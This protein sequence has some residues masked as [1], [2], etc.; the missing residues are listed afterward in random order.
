MPLVLQ[1]ALAWAAGTALGLSRVQAGVVF[2]AA[3]LLGVWLV[4][5]VIALPGDRMERLEGTA[6]LALLFAVALGVGAD[7]ARRDA[8]CEATARTARS[9]RVQLRREAVPGGFA[10]GLIA[11]A[12]CHVRVAIAV[13]VGN[14]V[15]GSVVRVT[16]AEASVG[17]RGLLLRDAVL[18]P[19]S[20]P[21]ALHR[22]RNRVSAAIDR[23]FGADAGLAKALLIADTDGL[24]PDLRD[25][26]ADAGL[27]HILSISGLHVGIIGAALLLF[28][29]AARLPATAGRIGAVLVV[30]IYVLAIGAPAAAVRSAALFTAVTATRL[31]QRPTSPWAT[32]A[33][34][35]LVP[36]AQP[37]TALDL[38]WQLS[39]SGY[40]G[41]IAAG[42]LARR[43]RWTGWR[44]ALLR[45]LMA[46]AL[47]TA[48]TAPLVAWHFGRL[49]LVAIV[50]NLGAGPV[51]AVLQPTL[52][53][54]MLA[55]GDALGRFVA[56]AARPMLRALDAV[57][58]L[59]AAVPGGAVDVAPT[60]AMVTVASCT[61]AL[62][63]VAAVARHWGPWAIAAGAG[64]AVM[65]WAPDVPTRS[66]GRLEVHVLDVGQGDA[67]ALRTPAGRWV[68]VDAGR[69]WSS[70]DAGRT[71]IIPY[72]R[73]RGGVL[74]LFV[75]TH[76]HA[77]HVGG[78]ASVIEALRPALVRDAAFVAASPA[79][80]AMLASARRRGGQWSR[81]V[82]GERVS[83]D[84]VALTFLAPDS[85]WTAGLDDPNEASTIL[86][87]E[88]GARSLLLT[89]DAEAGLEQW[90][91]GHAIEQLDVDLLKVAHHG[92]STSSTPAFL[93]AVSP[94]LGLVSVGRDNSYG[95]PSP[96]VM[97]R[98]LDAGATV[99]RT[100][101]L[102]TLVLRTDGQVW[103]A[104]VAGQRWPLRDEPAPLP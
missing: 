28:V 73:R 56:D 101:Q 53:L 68:L 50:S 82:P 26:Y 7:L 89:G 27:V 22:W 78:A 14:A 94:R 87:V 29:E 36:L 24:T 49:S 31:L 4:W 71:T 47:T 25:R 19:A 91:L 63:I 99:L 97:R 42:R 58:A 64:I 16:R 1:A 35:A 18:E 92:S 51:V 77:D 100:D 32:Y 104:E 69:S 13:R 66:T 81:V 86:R 9:W 102:G 85:A 96:D 84:G 48:A 103:E 79:Y 54:A 67:I 21:S 15:A 52:F 30:G 46:G 11:D 59:A 34:A 45:E 76:P 6:G 2:G 65:A 80:A 23:R 43:S 88:Y 95:H 39:V 33:I 90:L 20:P 37:R 5:R 75:L 72:L 38:G 41:L 83:L 10:T 40:A 8:H 61:A 57:A 93:D 70:G 60:L 3:L 55:P 62:V 17:E 74:A 12:G 44:G 98:L